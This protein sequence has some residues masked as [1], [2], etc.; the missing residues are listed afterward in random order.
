[1]AIFQALSRRMFLSEIGRATIAVAIFGGLAACGDDDS[2]LAGEDGSTT[3]NPAPK[4][5]TSPPSA[6]STTEPAPQ[7]TA[8]L[9]AVTWRRVSLGFVSAYVLARSGEAV[10]VDTGVA[11]SAPQIE[12]GLSA[13]GLGWNDV[14]HVILTHLH[15]DHIGSIGDV[16]TSADAATG[17][18][19]AADIGAIPSPRPLRAV[20]DGDDVFGLRIIATPGHTA[21]HISV[22]DAVGGLLVAGDAIN[23]EDGGVIGPRPEFTSDMGAAIESAIKLGSLTF[24]TVVFGHGD[25]VEGGADARVAAMA[26]G[27]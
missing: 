25:P 27:L 7:A 15:P 20:G 19:G 10:V 2:A 3:A 8:G 24:D 9:E 23:G 17:Y 6:T 12:A 21:G 16:L 14:G 4:S 1:M 18:A 11:G 22:L 26:A 13:I 5:S